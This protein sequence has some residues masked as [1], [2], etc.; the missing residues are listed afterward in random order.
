M[1]SFILLTKKCE[2]TERNAGAQL[3]DADYECA[4]RER[5]NDQRDRQGVKYFDDSSDLIMNLGGLSLNTAILPPGVTLHEI[6]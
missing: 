1:L 2:W 6:L 3:Y 4:V 5:D